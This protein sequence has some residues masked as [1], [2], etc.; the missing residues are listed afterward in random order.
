MFIAKWKNLFLFGRETDDIGAAVVDANTATIAF[1][2][3]YFYGQ[4]VPPVY[5]L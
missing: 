4:S 1:F 3:V 2:G 5:F